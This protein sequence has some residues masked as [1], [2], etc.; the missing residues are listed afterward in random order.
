MKILKIIFPVVFIFSLACSRPDES[1]VVK[2]IFNAA[3]SDS[4]SYQT[5]HKLSKVYGHRLGGSEQSLKAVEYIKSVM[6]SYG[7]D[8]VYTQQC[9]VAHWERGERE[10]GKIFSKIYNGLSVNIRALGNSIATPIGGIKSGV[11]EVNS[12]EDLD[13]LGEKKIKGKIV[14]F[15]AH[16]NSGYSNPFQ[17]YGEVVK[18]RFSG[19]SVAA[20][21]GALAVIVRSVTT[22]VDTF[23]HTG[24]MHYDEL[25]NQIPAVTIATKH[26]DILSESLKIDPNLAFYLR[27]NCKTL[28][29]VVSY[30]VIGEIRGIVYPNEIITVGG[31]LDT[32]DITEGAH[33]DGA[34]CVQSIEV[35]R[36]LKKV[37]YQPK[38][39]I[40]AVMFMDEEMNQRG[41]RKYA[42][43]AKKNGEQHIFALEADMGAGKPLGFNIGADSIQFSQFQ[44]FVKYF[45][46]YS[47]SHFQV[48]GGGADISFLHNLN[49]VLCLF[50]TDPANYFNYHHCANDTFEQIEFSNLQNGSAAMATLVY[51]TDKFILSK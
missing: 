42:E 9:S 21:Y 45:E 18:Y 38:R 39:T 17:G 31:H 19:A 23:P 14:F 44:P 1:Q 5:L 28:A 48:G 35:L 10:I 32:W 22:S 34:G 3:L 8:T 29:D 50:I 37:G 36:L 40:R 12:F 43:L 49:P 41:A 46:P 47:I 26:A 33:D 11:I 6:S 24:V 4:T 27:A 20:Q 2:D 15:N 16:M 51:L 7:F 13:S 25:T 30:N